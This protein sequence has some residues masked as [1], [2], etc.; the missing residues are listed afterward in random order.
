MTRLCLTIDDAP[1][2]DEPGTTFDPKRMD[3]MLQVL[4]TE[5]WRD[6]CAFVIGARADELILRRW[7]DA[8]FAL[9][10]HSW[11]HVPASQAGAS[12][13]LE[14]AVR[15]DRLLTD[16]GAFDRHPKWF[17]FPHLDRGADADDRRRIQDGLE[18]MGYRMAPASVEIYDHLF[19]PRFDEAAEGGD[20][21]AVL[22]RYLSVARRSLEIELR[23]REHGQID[24]PSIAYVHFGPASRA[25]FPRLIRIIRGLGFVEATLDEALGDPYYRSILQDFEWNGLVKARP[26]ASLRRRILRRVNKLGLKAG[27]FDQ[28]RLG[29]LWPYL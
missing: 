9:G 13:F 4:N 18:D 14:S 11:D 7:L 19:D 5:G 1:S 16:L 12:A 21:Q 29:E 25:A 2:V 17:R 15:C 27:L 22:N 3:Q 8:G 28:G 23:D 6:C 10:N 24:A 20:S 26:K